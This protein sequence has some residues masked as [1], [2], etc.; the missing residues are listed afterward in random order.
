M[1][2]ELQIP[3]HNENDNTWPI[4]NGNDYGITDFAV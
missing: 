2:Y 3:G 4:F 1:S